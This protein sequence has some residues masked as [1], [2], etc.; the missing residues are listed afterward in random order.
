MSARFV[1]IYQNIQAIGLS[2]IRTNHRHFGH[3]QYSKSYNNN[4]HGR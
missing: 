3:I 1:I 4:P 2:Q